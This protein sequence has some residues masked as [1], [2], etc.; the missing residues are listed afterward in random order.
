MIAATGN[1]AVGQ[2]FGP[3]VPGFVHVEAGDIEALEDAIDP[4]IAGVLMEPIQGE[5][6][7]NL[8]PPEYAAKVRRIC[9]EHL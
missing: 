5:G 1:P 6:G 9:D 4:E 2:G 8:Y 3:P 7:V